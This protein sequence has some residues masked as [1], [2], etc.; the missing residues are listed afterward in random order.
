MSVITRIS[1]LLCLVFAGSVS[2]ATI[3]YSTTNV[4]GNTWLYDYTITNDTLGT[5]L[6]EFTI[7]FDVALY[8]NLVVESS[9]TDW[10][11]LA[12]DPDPLLPDDGFFDSVALISGI[13]PGDTL[14]GFSVSFD[15]LGAGMPGAQPFDIVDPNTFAV[16]ENGF[17]TPATVVPVPAAVWLFGSG[18]LMLA[19]RLRPARRLDIVA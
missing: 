13:A 14:S 10:D 7:Y 16:L 17:T 3:T 19:G 18:L 6:E 1:T 8:A 15:F 5:P 11:P 2:A 12:V 9:P 4:T